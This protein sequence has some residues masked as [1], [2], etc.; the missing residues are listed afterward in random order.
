M[1]V[2]LNIIVYLLSTNHPGLLDA[3]LLRSG[4]S[5][6]NIYSGI[7]TGGNTIKHEN[8]CKISKAL[9]SNFNVGDVEKLSQISMFSG[10]N[11]ATMNCV[12]R[13]LN[14]V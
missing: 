2:K 12:K 11:Q 5:D 6:K 10:V 3:S 4:R 9:T 1:Y 7:N 14:N 8:K 13:L